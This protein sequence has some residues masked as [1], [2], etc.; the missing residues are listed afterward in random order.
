MP[1]D[2]TTQKRSGAIKNIESTVHEVQ[3]IFSQLGGLLVE[4]GERLERVDT[5]LIYT[6][7]KVN[8]AQDQ[9]LKYY[10]NIQRNR[11]LALKLFAIMIIMILIIFYFY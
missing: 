6:G 8:S 7:K 2:T 10:R 3:G 4:Q 11:K 5:N 1:Q 9:I